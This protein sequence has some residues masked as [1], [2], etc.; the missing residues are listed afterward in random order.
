MILSD[1]R[2]Y[3]GEKYYY[4]LSGCDGKWKCRDQ[5]AYDDRQISPIAKVPG[6]LPGDRCS[7]DRFIIN[8]PRIYGTTNPRGIK[9]ARAHHVPNAGLFTRIGASGLLSQSYFLLRIC[10]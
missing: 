5:Y 2:G 10:Y 4:I 9:A 6:P 1:L 8:I 7:G 3:Q